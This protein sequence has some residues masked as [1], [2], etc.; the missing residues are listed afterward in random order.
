MR[1]YEEEKKHQ[2]K[3]KKVCRQQGEGTATWAGQEVEP[4][5][6]KTSQATEGGGNKKQIERERLKRRN[7]FMQSRSSRSRGGGGGGR[8]MDAE[9][10][11]TGNMKLQTC[12]IFK[13]GERR[14]KVQRVESWGGGRGVWV[15]VGDG[16]RVRVSESQRRVKESGSQR[17]SPVNSSYLVAPGLAELNIVP[18]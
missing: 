6:R 1:E 3:G 2:L 4:W 9:K 14:R 15:E 18:D 10:G 8:A 16:W 7:E 13:V 17:E 11:P 12:R 5:K